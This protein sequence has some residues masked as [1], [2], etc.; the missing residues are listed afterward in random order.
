MFDL[1][2]VQGRGPVLFALLIMR[3]NG[4]LYTVIRKFGKED[5]Q[6]ERICDYH[7]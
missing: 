1:T 6:Y 3:F 2:K 4:I 7:G 5:R